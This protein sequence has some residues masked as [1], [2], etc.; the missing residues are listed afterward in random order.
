MM[1]PE[2]DTHDYTLT[3]NTSIQITCSTCIRSDRALTH[4]PTHPPKSHKC[5][6]VLLPLFTRLG[7]FTQHQEEN[8][9]RG[10]GEVG[11][12]GVHVGVGGLI[13]FAFGTQTVQSMQIDKQ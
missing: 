9:G 13:L 11:A 4:G 3:A 5:C 8:G 12:A 2:N 10:G 6:R 1:R 7:V